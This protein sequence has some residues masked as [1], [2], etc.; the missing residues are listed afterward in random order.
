MKNQYKTMV[1]AILFPLLYVETSTAAV[2]FVDGVVD[3]RA[4]STV[5]NQGSSSGV[6]TDNPPAINGNSGV[7]SQSAS[8]SAGPV[9]P[10][11]VITLPGT[12][13]VLRAESM[14]Q[15]DFN[16]PNGVSGNVFLGFYEDAT[17]LGTYATNG[18]SDF[19]TQFTVDEPTDYELMGSYN[20]FPEDPVWKLQLIG[21]SG[22]LVNASTEGGATSGTFNFSGT[23]LPGTTYQLTATVSANFTTGDVSGTRESMIDSTLTFPGLG[24]PNQDP[25]ETAVPIWSFPTAVMM[26]LGLLT[27]ARYRKQL[28]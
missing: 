27:I 3:T 2:S 14:S 25:E 15:I 4:V 16:E 9:A 7:L 24:E 13:R 12:T 23:L 8:A 22:V 19:S 28:R 20:V 26:G 17:G 6:E 21:A 5:G 1:G 11:A 18:V 10:G